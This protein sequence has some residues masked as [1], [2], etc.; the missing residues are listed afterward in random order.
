MARASDSPEPRP[1]VL[2]GVREPPGM[3]LDTPPDP[4]DAVYCGDMLGYVKMVPEVRLTH[5]TNKEHTM[6]K[7]NAALAKAGVTADTSSKNSKS[8]SLEASVSLDVKKKVDQYLKALHDMQ[9]LEAEMKLLC[10]DIREAGIEFCVKNQ[11]SEN[12]I[13]SGLK[14]GSVNVNFKDQYS[15][16]DENGKEIAIAE[17]QRLGVANPDNVI[18]EKNTMTFNFD[19]L[20]EQEQKK[21]LDFVSKTLGPDRFALVAVTKTVYKVGDFKSFLLTNAK[22]VETFNQVAKALRMYA[23][24]VAERK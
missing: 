3:S 2:G 10:A 11:I 18:K 5:N 7:M 15:D 21:L 12:I 19:A 13:I 6:S 4:P 14:E 8:K 22:T 1:G 20:N 24:T 16:L 9:N 23:P 17:L